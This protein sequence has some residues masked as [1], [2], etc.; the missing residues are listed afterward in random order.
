MDW[1]LLSHE[2]DHESLKLFDDPDTGIRG[3]IAVHSTALGP[4]MGGLRLSRYRNISEATADALRL[5]RAMSLKNAAAGLDLGGGKAVLLDDGAW[6]GKRRDIR[7]RAFGAQVDRLGGSYVTAEDV[8]TSPADMQ[9]IATQTSYVAGLPLLS[10]GRGDPSPA[11]AMTVFAAIGSGVESALGRPSLEGVR[12][13]VEGVGHVGAV[14]VRMLREA[15]AIVQVCD[16][17]PGRAAAVAAESGAEAVSRGNFL[18]RDFDVLAPC[19]LGGVVTESVV[20]A[21]RCRVVAGAANNQLADPAVA[22]L[23]D[24]AGILYVPDFIANCGGIIHVGAE[25]LGLDEEEARARITTACGRTAELLGEAAAKGRT[26]L[27]VATA[28]A[29]ARLRQGIA[30]AAGS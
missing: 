21:M 18:A 7:M 26:P 23:L 29:E 28:Q 6:T 25:P 10:G 1:D 12:V 27:E 9:S 20:V 15:G 14:L 8:G 19:A 17:D 11:T 30:T 16:L 5:A 13:G 2:F 24:R 3:C 22:D 4:A